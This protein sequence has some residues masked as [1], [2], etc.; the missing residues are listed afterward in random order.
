[1]D[2]RNEAVRK[3]AK[4]LDAIC[5]KQGRGILIVPVGF[6]NQTKDDI[7]SYLYTNLNPFEFSQA[8]FSAWVNYRNMTTVP[9]MREDLDKMMAAIGKQMTKPQKSIEQFLSSCDEEEE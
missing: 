4:K 2:P 6:A 5:R 3:Y 9:E 7:K 1:M 8:I